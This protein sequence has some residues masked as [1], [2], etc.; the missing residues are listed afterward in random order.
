MMISSEVLEMV[1][2]ESGINRASAKSIVER[3]KLVM[4]EKAV[5][6][7]KYMNTLLVKAIELGI[8]PSQND[9][10]SEQEAVKLLGKSPAFLRVARAQNRLTPNCVISGDKYRYTFHD[11]AEYMAKIDSYKPL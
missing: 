6:I 8:K 5:D 2:Y 4:A 9:T 11:L 10:I 1:L 3:S 7:Q